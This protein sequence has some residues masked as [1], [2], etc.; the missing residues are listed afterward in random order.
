MNSIKDVEKSRNA[1]NYAGTALMYLTQ[2]QMRLGGPAPEHRLDNAGYV[3]ILRSARAHLEMADP[4]VDPHRFSA[5]KNAL[6]A[7]EAA[8]KGRCDLGAVKIFNAHVESIHGGPNDID[9]GGKKIAN[10]PT[11]KEVFLRAAA[12]ALW[13]EFPKRRDSLTREAKKLLGILDQEAL[14]RLVDNFNQRHNV[15]IE[16]SRSPISIHMAFVKDLVKKHGYH[17]LSDFT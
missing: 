1:I 4:E 6:E 9:F 8:E 3:A 2:M 14:A 7:L 10:K 16:R 17:K 5:A 11:A 15:E 12:I 13:L